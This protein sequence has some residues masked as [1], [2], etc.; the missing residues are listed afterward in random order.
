MANSV[1]S[2]IAVMHISFPDLMT[3]PFG[4]G[5]KLPEP[6]QNRIVAKLLHDPTVQLKNAAGTPRGERLS[7]AL[8]ALFDL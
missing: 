1:I 8:R 6:W 4:R 7:E 2:V 5:M 3:V